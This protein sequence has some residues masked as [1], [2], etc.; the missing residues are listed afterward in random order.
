MTHLHRLV[1]FIPEI[2]LYYI[3]AEDTTASHLLFHL[4]SKKG[5]KSK[6]QYK[7]Y[8]RTK[9]DLTSLVTETMHSGVYWRQF[10]IW[11]NQQ[12]I[13]KYC[14]SITKITENDI[15]LFETEKDPICYQSKI[16]NINLSK[17]QINTNN[18]NDC[19]YMVNKLFY[20]LNQH[21]SVDS[22]A[23]DM[24][25][26]KSFIFDN[27]LEIEKMIS[28]YDYESAAYCSSST[29]SLWSSDLAWYL[30]GGFIRSILKC[31]Q[32]EF[33]TILQITLIFVNEVCTFIFT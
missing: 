4:T 21:L 9:W 7:I 19:H 26:F 25:Y 14:K 22:V 27:P 1:A 3:I 20:A 12:Q 32:S 15:K 31:S 5:Q 2:H 16:Q 13:D 8:T 29:E 30:V 18:I 23:I 11:Y 10:Q 28:H 6:Q 17:T 33:E 24:N